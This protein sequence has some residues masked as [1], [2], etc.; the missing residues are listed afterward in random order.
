MKLTLEQ[1]IAFTV[2]ERLLRTLGK[3]VLVTITPEFE[4]IKELTSS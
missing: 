3:E 1:V 4:V 2:V